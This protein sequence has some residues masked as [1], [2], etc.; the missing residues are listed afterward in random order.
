VVVCA[1]AT[2]TNA[3]AA[4]SVHTN[5]EVNIIRLPDIRRERG[6]FELCH[7]ARTSLSSSQM[8]APNVASDKDLLRSTSQPVSEYS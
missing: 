2:E 1:S 8:M 7:S 3:L 6:E 5:R 4:A